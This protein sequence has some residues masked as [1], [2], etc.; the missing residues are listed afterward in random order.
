LITFVILLAI[1]DIFAGEFGSVGTSPWLL[2]AGLPFSVLGL[3]RGCKLL[4]Y[5]YD[6]I[7]HSPNSPKREEVLGA[8]FFVVLQLLVAAVVV[9]RKIPPDNYTVL[10]CAV[11]SVFLPM[12]EP[13]ASK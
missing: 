8:I 5:V 1:V 12:P 6:T 3:V 7:V 10:V 9:G 13:P 4:V 2:I 11:A